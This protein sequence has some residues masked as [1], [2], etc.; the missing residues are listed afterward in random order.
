[1]DNA[2]LVFNVAPTCA[3]GGGLVVCTTVS[4]CFLG[5]ASLLSRLNLSCRASEHLLPKR[6][7]AS[8]YAHSR[9]GCSP[10]S[11]AL[12]GALP[13]GEWKKP[14]VRFTPGPTRAK[15]YR[16]HVRASNVRQRS[17]VSIQPRFVLHRG[18]CGNA[19]W[20]CLLLQNLAL[21]KYPS[22]VRLQCRDS[23]ETEQSLSETRNTSQGPL[24]Q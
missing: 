21:R 5:S 8:P 12:F 4:Q 18:S 7:H 10:P 11:F 6:P 14:A 15:T 19:E 9:L 17:L 2:A 24:D 1:M 20:V 16:E 22:S 3:G 23:V 13:S